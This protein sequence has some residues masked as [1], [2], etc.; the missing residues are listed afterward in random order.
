MIA[1]DHGAGPEVFVFS[2][3]NFN[4]S[5]LSDTS[6]YNQNLRARKAT[7]RKAAKT[8]NYKEILIQSLTKFK[9]ESNFPQKSPAQADPIS[10][11]PDPNKN[12]RR[13]S[14]TVF[15]IKLPSSP[16]NPQPKILDGLDTSL[17]LP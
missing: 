11:T 16:P 10:P 7:R 2:C 1:A 4:K 8:Q 3:V 12:P 15:G 9:L 17:P 13:R 6:N 14:I 5:D